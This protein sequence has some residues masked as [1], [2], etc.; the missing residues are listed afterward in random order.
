MKKISYIIAAV[1]LI[2]F[3]S[4][5]ATYVRPEPPPLRAEIIGVAPYPAFVWVKGHWAWRPARGGYVWISGHYRGS[6]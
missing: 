4:G 5:C 2:P 6:Y 3:L 1:V